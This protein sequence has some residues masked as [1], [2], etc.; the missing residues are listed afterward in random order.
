VCVRACVCAFVCVCKRE[1]APRVHVVVSVLCM[2]RVR[3]CVFLQHTAT[4]C[5]TLQHTVS[6]NAETHKKSTYT[7]THTHT[8]IHAHK[9]VRE[10]DKACAR[11]CVYYRVL[12]GRDCKCCA[13]MV[14]HEAKCHHMPEKSMI[15]S[16]RNAYLPDKE[17][18][19]AAIH[20]RFSSIAAVISHRNVMINTEV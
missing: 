2:C 6:G 9:R 5:N 7:H 16:S 19:A 11:V 18:C 13:S 3:L 20:F 4:H 17:P 1:S 10:T 12:D 8:H 15:L 14:Q